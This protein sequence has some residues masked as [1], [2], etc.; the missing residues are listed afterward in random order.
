MVRQSTLACALVL[1]LLVLGCG[2][3]GGDGGEHGRF[4]RFVFVPNPAEDTV[5]VYALEHESGRLQ[6][7]SA[8][9]TGLSPFAAAVDPSGS[10]VYVACRA[11]DEVSQ[12]RIQSDNSLQPLATPTISVGN[13]PV[14]IALDPTGI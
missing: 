7:V 14:S 6:F 10:H 4:G 8:A 5:S 3:G 12:Y 9:P 1:C 13:E 11:S 2:G